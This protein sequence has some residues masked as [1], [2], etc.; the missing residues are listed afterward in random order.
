MD[1]PTTAGPGG[2]RVAHRGDPHAPPTTVPVSPGPAD[3]QRPAGRQR[4]EVGAPPVT[5]GLR[6]RGV[7]VGVLGTALMLALAAVGVVVVRPGPVAGWLG[8]AEAPTASAPAPSE[9]APSPVLAAAAADAPVPTAQGIR[10]AVDALVHDADLGP[11]VGVS[12]VDAT[13]GESLYASGAGMP[14]TPAS[15]TKLITAATVLEARGP[16]YRIPTR[17]VAGDRPGEVV[18]IGGGDPTLAV[19]ATATYPGAARLDQLAAQVRAALGGATPTRVIV[20]SSLFTGPVYGPGWDDDIPTGG[21]AGPITALM[22]DGARINPKAAPAAERYDN[23]D[24]A[25]GQAF[26]RAL[27]L[28]AV[29]VKATTRGTAPADPGAA[30]G[31]GATVT[32]GGATAGA[33]PVAPGAQL[34]VVVSPPMIRLVELMLSAS[35]NVIAES[36][37]RQVALAKDEPASYAGAVAAMDTVIA[38]LGLDP[39]QAQLS[40]GSGL[41][42]R[43]RI[44]PALLT[45]LLSL[46]ASGHQR[47]ADLLGGLPVA[48]W[49]GTL[50]DRYGVGEAGSRVGAGVVRAKTG[51]LRGVHAIS[52]V[53]QTVDGRLLAFAVLADQVPPAAADPQAALDRIAATL[54]TCGCR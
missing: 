26:A 45:D 33:A 46:A 51:T 53:V 8:G 22:T 35:D 5:S 42:R 7:V 11:R 27:G 32:P 31:P 39:D 30:A 16:A 14:T 36:L 1:P 18:L 20:D 47:V 24:L 48:G 21:F 10:D 34:G 38:D 2:P 43:N 25:A 44:S 9:A 49:S 40:D 15:T 29:A 17:A 50:R 28:P 6:R 23:P 4:P 52:G 37:A 13:S 12:V 41:S 3:P 54:A 19:N